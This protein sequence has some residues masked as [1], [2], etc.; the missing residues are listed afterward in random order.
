MLAREGMGMG[1]GMGM[2]IKMGIGRARAV[3]LL[4]STAQLL[5]SCRPARPSHHALRQPQL[6]SRRFCCAAAACFAL[7]SLASLRLVLDP[8]PIP[9]L[10]PLS[11]PPAPY[12]SI[13]YLLATTLHLARAIA[14]A[15]TPAHHPTPYTLIPLLRQP[16]A[17]PKVLPESMVSRVHPFTL[18]QPRH[19]VS[20]LRST[21]LPA[22][23]CYCYCYCYCCRHRY[24]C[25]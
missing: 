1:K 21:P 22:C 7:S 9:A 10:L 20:I 19:S 11:D 23:Y 18:N 16:S 24:C 12:Q 3:L 14:V 13:M 15:V 8:A 5:S 25:P 6:T 2:G 17:Y 4:K